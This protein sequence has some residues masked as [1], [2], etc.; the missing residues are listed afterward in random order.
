MSLFILLNEDQEC[1]CY[2]PSI[3]YFFQK[4]VSEILP[5]KVIKYKEKNKANCLGRS[6]KLKTKKVNTQ[7]QEEYEKSNEFQTRATT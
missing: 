2:S 1:L 5:E 6:M 3:G 7:K 4:I